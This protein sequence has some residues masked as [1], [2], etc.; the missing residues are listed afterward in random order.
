[1]VLRTVDLAKIMKC[2]SSYISL[3]LRCSPE[4]LGLLCENKELKTFW[5]KGM[6]FATDY[7]SLCLLYHETKNTWFWNNYCGK[8]IYF[9]WNIFWK[10]ICI[11]R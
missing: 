1:M 3:I 8:L 7:P 9:T 2:R 4:G 6:P 11:F 10:L 5:K